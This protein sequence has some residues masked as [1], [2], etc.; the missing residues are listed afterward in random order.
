M[1]SEIFFQQQLEHI[2]DGLEQTGWAHA[3][4]SQPIL[5][6]RADATLSVNRI[7]NHRQNY[8]K[9]NAKDFQKRREDEERIH[10]DLSVLQQLRVYNAAIFFA[11]VML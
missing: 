10:L 8:E 7:R 2:C 6:K 9:Q 3:I 5:N 4:R 11:A 1:R